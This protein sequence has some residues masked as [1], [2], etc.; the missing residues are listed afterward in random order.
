MRGTVVGKGDDGRKGLLHIL[1]RA[2]IL[3][4]GDAAMVSKDLDKLLRRLKLNLEELVCF[5]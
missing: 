1:S 5:K 3:I 4:A 2:P